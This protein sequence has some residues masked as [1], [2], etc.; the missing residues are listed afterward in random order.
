MSPSSPLPVGACPTADVEPVFERCVRLEEEVESLRHALDTKSATLSRMSHELRTP[1]NAV[2]GFADLLSEGVA[3]PL[4]VEQ[5]VYV[6]DI[7]SAGRHLLAVINDVLDLAKLEAGAMRLDRELVEL[8]LPVHQAEEMVRPLAAK[9]QIQLSTRVESSAVACG[10]LQRLRQVALNLFANAIKFTPQGGRV[11]ARVR[12]IDG[13]PELRVEDTGIGIDPEQHEAVFREFHQVPG[14]AGAAKEG[15]G[16]GLTL[17][18]RFVEQM[19]GTVR[20]ESRLGAGA[21]FIVRLRPPADVP[22]LE[23]RVQLRR[24]LPSTARLALI[25]ARPR[26]SP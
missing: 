12:V 13:A 3:G 16:L 26:V 10:D 9:K 14:A 20:V 1:M 18:K 19:G 2:L 11:T 23:R 7:L 5:G 6:R 22:A 4:S 15:T 17:V 25:R 8:E 21:T 24:R